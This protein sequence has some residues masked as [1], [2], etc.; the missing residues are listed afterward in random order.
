MRNSRVPRT[1]SWGTRHAIVFSLEKNAIY[2][3]YIQI[4]SLQYLIY[5][6]KIALETYISVFFL[7]FRFRSGGYNTLVATCVGEEGLDIGEV[8]LIVLFDVSK[9]PIRQEIKLYCAVKYSS[10]LSSWRSNHI[11]LF[12]VFKF[13]IKLEV[14]PYCA[15]YKKTKIQ[16]VK[17]KNYK[18]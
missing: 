14:K 3:Q 9:S 7:S 17:K 15:I 2:T 1:L 13:L 16:I 4:R 10:F 18:I 8:D 5:L 6:T 12:E 11:V